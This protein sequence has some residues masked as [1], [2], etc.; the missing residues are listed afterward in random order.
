MNTNNPE[1]CRPSSE[2]G[3][4][5]DRT[6]ARFPN[7]ADG[8]FI[9]HNEGFRRYLFDDIQWVEASGN[10]SYLHLS[11]GRSVLVVEQL[12]RLE[13]LFPRESFI[14]IH[15][16]YMV[17]RGY[18]DGIVGNQLCIGSVRLSVGESYRRRTMSRFLVLGMR[19]GL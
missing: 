17:N 6:D 2:C 9:R 12:S 15:R 19:C 7:D 8:I 3:G 13:R 18:V 5:A 4:R 16:S 11:D 1:K 14:R 10:Y